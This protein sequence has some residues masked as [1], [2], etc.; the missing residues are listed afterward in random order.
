MLR[1][2]A[3]NGNYTTSEV[4]TISCKHSSND[5]TEEKTHGLE[6]DAFD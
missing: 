3:F 4:E 1:P 6:V 5:V 2:V